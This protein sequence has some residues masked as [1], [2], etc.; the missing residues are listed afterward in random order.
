[1]NQKVLSKQLK[2]NGYI[3]HVAN[4]GRE[5]LD[6]LQTSRHWKGNEDG[7]DLTVILMDVVSRNEIPTYCVS[8]TQANSYLQE[9]PVVSISTPTKSH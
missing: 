4:H 5:A 2:K 1:V 3:V 6:F 7:F 8:S 9:M